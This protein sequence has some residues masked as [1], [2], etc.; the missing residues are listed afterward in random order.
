MNFIPLIAILMFSSSLASAMGGRLLDFPTDLPQPTSFIREGGACK[1]ARYGRIGKV[2]G[3]LVT[4]E[5]F[6]HQ[7]PMAVLPSASLEARFCER[8]FPE[9]ASSAFLP[10]YDMPAELL[11]VPSSQLKQDAERWMAEKKYSV[12]SYRYRERATARNVSSFESYKKNTSVESVDVQKIDWDLLLQFNF[13][14]ADFWESALACNGDAE[15]VRSAYKAGSGFCPN[16]KGKDEELVANLRM[17]RENFRSYLTS[18]LLPDFKGAQIVA[19]FHPLFTQMLLEDLAIMTRYVGYDREA[20]PFVITQQYKFLRNDPSTR[21]LYQ[22]IGDSYHMG[23]KYVHEYAFTKFLSNIASLLTIV[24]DEQCENWGLWPGASR[25]II[26]GIDKIWSDY[27][28]ADTEILTAKINY[29][30]GNVYEEGLSVYDYYGK[31]NRYEFVRTFRS[32]AAQWSSKD[33]MWPMKL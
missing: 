8:M 5:D 27:M 1:I 18:T 23:E 11:H 30:C 10:K 26:Y 7:M 31:H 33:R 3:G 32:L 15:K 2:N 16:N 9:N 19:R 22:S 17:L 14:A 29:A 4:Y 20:M 25:S 13:A 6:D 21:M 12:S 28:K 24:P